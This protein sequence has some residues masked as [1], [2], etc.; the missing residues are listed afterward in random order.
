MEVVN[1]LT[2]NSIEDVVRNAMFC[3]PFQV[4][5]HFSQAGFWLS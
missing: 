5:L 1:D 2:R 4:V 3:A